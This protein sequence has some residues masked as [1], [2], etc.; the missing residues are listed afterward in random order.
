MGMDFEPG[1]TS[2]WIRENGVRLRELRIERRIS[3]RQ[4]AAASGVYASQVCR[5]EAGRDARISTLLKIYDGLGY[6][7]EFE[8][9]E[10]CEEA[11]ELL[12]KESWRRQERRDA[13]LLLGKRWR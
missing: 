3:R 5:A 12:S 7:V 1:W 10:T 8:L 6:R 9:Q 13:G 2:H 4:L 11:G